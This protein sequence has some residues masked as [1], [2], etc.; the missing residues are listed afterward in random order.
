[1]ERGAALSSYVTKK[2]Q[3]AK[4]A[5]EDYGKMLYSAYNQ[6]TKERLEDLKTEDNN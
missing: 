5:G 1:M 4:Y 3:K 2:A 6:R